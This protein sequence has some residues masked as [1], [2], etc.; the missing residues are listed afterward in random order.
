METVLVIA[1]VLSNLL[2]LFFFDRAEGRSK[3]ERRELQNRIAKPEMIVPPAEV[4]SE[5]L[6]AAK[7]VRE[8]DDPFAM[9]V[10][11]RYEHAA[12][13]EVNPELI[14]TQEMPI[15]E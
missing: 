12:V 10:E 14:R 2:W 6:E 15:R 3:D 7:A 4:V 9:S 5:R 1:L 8:T 11:E 13:G